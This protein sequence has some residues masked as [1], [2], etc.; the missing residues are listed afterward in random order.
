MN[1]PNQWS[2]ANF[3]NGGLELRSLSAGVGPLKWRE[4]SLV[5]FFST[6]KPV[7][8]TI[9]HFTRIGCPCDDGR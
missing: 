8:S 9:Q 6:V 1:F 5:D 3:A 2:V 7:R 4:V